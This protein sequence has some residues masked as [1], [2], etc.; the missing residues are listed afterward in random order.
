[1]EGQL[2]SIDGPITL[3]RKM[4][5]QNASGISLMMQTIVD[6]VFWDMPVRDFV[7]RVFSLL[8]VVAKD[9]ELMKRHSIS[10]TSL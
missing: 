5:I 1:M 3:S 4:N 9:E 7:C 6:M 10:S 8:P 2:V